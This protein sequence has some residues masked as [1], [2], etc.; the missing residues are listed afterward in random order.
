MTGH[1]TSHSRREKK[2]LDRKLSRDEINALDIRRYDG[3]LELVR[4]KRHM[5]NAVRR[6]K[7]E[8]LLGFD[9]E[10]RP[11]FKKNVSYPTSLLQLAARNCV[12]IFQLK[13]LDGL[14]SLF[15]VLAAPKI[16][17]A[18]VSIKDDVKELC[19]LSD[20]EPAGF[21]D[22]GHCARKSGLHHHGLRGLAALLLGFRISKSQTRYNWSRDELSEAAIRYAATDAWIG[23]ELY[24]TM[25][26]RGCLTT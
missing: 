8:R 10:T 13:H 24:T 5:V 4:S 21:I 20:F 18:G 26:H 7:N 9:T 12:Y 16:V 3:P 2:P 22:I 19:D 15:S 25:K 1:G 11:A 17:K 14:S 6:L 23:R